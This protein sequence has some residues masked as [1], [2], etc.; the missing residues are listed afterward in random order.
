MDQVAIAVGSVRV[1]PRGTVITLPA[2]ALFVSDRT[3]FVPG[4]AEK[5]NLIAEA[6]QGRQARAITIEGFTDSQGNEASNRQLSQARAEAIRQYL[7]SRGLP[8]NDVHARGLG[9]VRPIADNGSI[10]G[11]ARNHRVEIVVESSDNP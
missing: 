7:V 4:A 2:G 9:G 6:L 5:L 10:A 3:T 8:A 11:R 1:D